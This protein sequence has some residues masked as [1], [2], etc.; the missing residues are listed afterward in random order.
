M[1]SLYVL[2]DEEYWW[3]KYSMKEEGGQD[4]GKEIQCLV[5]TMGNEKG[6]GSGWCV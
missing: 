3:S 1:V 2:W 6:N 4:E 5:L